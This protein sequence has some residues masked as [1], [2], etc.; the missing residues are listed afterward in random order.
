MLEQSLE[1]PIGLKLDLSASQFLEESHLEP[2]FN[3][4]KQSLKLTD[5]T[6]L[7]GHHMTFNDST[8]LEHH[9]KDQNSKK[10]LYIEIEERNEEI[11]NLKTQL[12]FVKER[13]ICRNIEDD[14]D[15]K[16]DVNIRSSSLEYNKMHTFKTIP[17]KYFKI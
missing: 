10:D 2:S 12:K 6:K 13:C 9:S 16:T 8:S 11:E 4:G 5:L 17:K 7:F 1:L 15:S 14:S 3:A